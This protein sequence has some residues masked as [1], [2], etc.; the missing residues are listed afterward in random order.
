M[1]AVFCDSDVSSVARAQKGRKIILG[2]PLAERTG[3]II[4]SNNVIWGFVWKIILGISDPPIKVE[5][6]LSAAYR[7]THY[8]TKGS[9]LP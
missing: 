8:P 5:T 9:V 3:N 7:Y 1:K 4:G 2:I 6:T